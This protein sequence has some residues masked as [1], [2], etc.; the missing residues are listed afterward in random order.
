KLLPSKDGGYYVLAYTGIHSEYQLKY[1]YLISLDSLGNEVWNMGID[2]GDQG[3]G[4]TLGDFSVAPDSNVYV[5]TNPN[6]CSGDGDVIKYDRFGN[7]IWDMQI[8]L[9]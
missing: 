5:A 8:D 7:Y 9:H 6:A 4:Y 2:F 1:S 3:I